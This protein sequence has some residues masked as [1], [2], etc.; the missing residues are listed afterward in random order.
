M[1]PSLDDIY[2]FYIEFKSK[3][4]KNA[5]AY[6]PNLTALRGQLAP[7]CPVQLLISVANEQGVKSGFCKAAG[8]AQSIGGYIQRLT[9][10][11]RSVSPY[12]LRIGGRTWY[13]S[14]GL[15]RQFVD[16]LGTWASPDASARYYRAS[17]WAV[18]KKL[19]SFYKTVELTE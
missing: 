7:M 18:F 1:L 12:A 9:E 5:L 3:T 8:K 2:G 4:M 16:Y 11:K 13:L 15:D 17:P 19:L 6:F 14:Q 10:C